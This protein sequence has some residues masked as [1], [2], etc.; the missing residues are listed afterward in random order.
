M[1]DLRS[2][3]VTKP[4]PE[5]LAHMIAAE[6]GDDV[7]AEDPTVNRFQQKV[8]ELFGFEA[9]LYVP[10]GVMSNQLSL[11]VA[12]EPGDEVIIDKKGHIF[13]YE[14]S[15]A[16]LL[17]SVQLY[18]VEGFHGKLTPELMASAHRGRHDWE[19]RSKVVVVENSTNKG[20]GVCYTREEL[21]DI[22]K[23]AKQLNLHV[24][25]DGARIWNAVKA[26]DIEPEYFGTIADTMSVCFSKGLG[27]P[28][29]SMVLS[30]EELIRAA[31]RRRKM[32]G[33][34]M[35]QVG[36]LAAAAEYAVD[37]HWEL[38]SEDHRRAQQLA[39]AIHGLDAFHIDTEYVETNILIFD[40]LAIPAE[41]VVERL[42]KHGVQIVPFGPN[43][44]R[45]TFHFQIDDD[46][47]KR[48]IEAFQTEFS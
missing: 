46:A 28:V 11:A 14:T 16:S 22:W 24:H 1:I 44:L 35:R 45:A 40:S 18:P 42:A 32:I 31:R 38:M 37:H 47:L 33:G 41:Q 43:T 15:A 4:T 12:T 17:S 19:P 29:G 8:A 48:V 27:A 21:A 20:G 9:G 23:A 13:N 30:S 36:L 6:V 3:T 7:F 39:E 34:G 2:D 10:T 5:M 26:T 25:V